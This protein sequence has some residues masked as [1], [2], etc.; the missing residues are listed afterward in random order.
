M[1]QDELYRKKCAAEEAIFS[2][3]RRGSRIFIGTGCA[4]PQYLVRALIKYAETHPKAFS[5]TEIFH[6]WSLGVTPY[7][8][9]KFKNN[10]RYNSFFIGGSVRAAVNEGMADYTPVFLSKVPGLF[11]RRIIP[12]DVALIQC[13]PPDTHGYMNLGVSVDIVKAALEV[14]SM[15]VVQIN[16]QSPIVHGDGFIHLNDIDFIVEADEP[17]LQYQSDADCD[18]VQAIGR[19]VST[20]IQDGD[21]LQV[22]YGSIP[23]AVMVHLSG[24]NN[25][26]I[27]TELI[28]DGIVDLIKNG[29]VNNIKKNINRSKTVASF[30]MGAQTTY[31]FINNNP[32]IEFR[33]I[34]YTNDPMVIASH[35]NM[36]AINS[37]LQLDL[38]G[39]AS[40][41]SIG[42]IFYSGIGGQADFMRGAVLSKGGKTILTL[43]STADVIDK[44]GAAQ[45]VSRIVPLLSKGAGV[46][47]NRGDIQYVVTEY[48]ISYLHGKNI[49]ERAMQLISI[50]H[51]EFRPWLIEEAKR[52]NLIYK[53]QATVTGNYPSELET[54]KRL[55]SGM[56]IFVRPV[57]I[58][59]EPLMKEFFY[60]LSDDTLYRR[61]TSV[62]KD[63]PHERL[64][65][66]IAVDYRSKIVI[67]AIM[68]TGN[69]ESIVGV[70]QYALSKDNFMAEVAF[71]VRDDYQGKGIGK[72]LIKY[73]TFIALKQGL[74]GFIA[75]TMS[76]NHSMIALFKSLDATIERYDED[77]S[78]S[79]RAIFK[80]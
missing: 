24:K 42:K 40:S 23:N 6:V 73:L 46:T 62:R 36:V 16:S 50:S 1:N 53:D 60:S 74:L 32:S 29:N 41:E 20:L 47:L 3:I 9:E 4:E 69:V 45:T 18:T 58:S 11:I 28:S 48:G 35:D 8:N 39:Q 54:H 49:R 5:D 7:T 65:E 12:V 22:G 31:D 27:H 17:I 15:V 64:Q 52:L 33:T 71:V 63:M 59:D 2:H 10:F 56:E 80:R 66:F 37:T 44:N 68:Q 75:E 78:C 67:V 55:S 57:K 25:L 13:S 76:E 79:L 19:Y 30:A 21:T 77:G 72:E 70:A 51:P 61:F 14:A 34:D 38:T 26:G 43:Q